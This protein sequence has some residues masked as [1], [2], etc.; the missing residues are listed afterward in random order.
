MTAEHALADTGPVASPV[1]ED[2]AAAAAEERLRAKVAEIKATQEPVPAP[3]EPAAAEP[4][5]PPVPDS[6]LSP[7]LAAVERRLSENSEERDRAL[8]D[9]EDRL[10]RVEQR[11]EDAER[12]AAFAE[13]LAQLKVEE[14][15]REKRL[16]D[17]VSGIDRAE[18]RAKEA[19]ARAEAAERAAAAALE[20]SDVNPPATETP[21]PQAQSASPAFAP[22]TPP[23][24]PAREEAPEAVQPE[25]SPAAEAPAVPERKGL[26]SPSATTAGA[27][28]S[29]VVNLNT[30]TFEELREVGLS[31][32]QATRI[33]AYR[34]RFGGYSSVEDLE[35]VPGFPADLIESL[36]GK[37]S[38]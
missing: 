13:R 29:D 8:R 2:A 4:Q 22:A 34:E 16:N 30:A 33:L 18:Q 20:K 14:S 32:T 1:E 7:G 36:K 11:A 27:N 35:K 19:E 12:R 38:V 10:R 24:P 28:A 9:A 6:D 23:A 26:F 3:A 37:I 31:V 21:A 17:V 5:T 25:S 15:E